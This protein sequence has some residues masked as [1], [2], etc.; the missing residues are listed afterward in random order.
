MHDKIKHL[1]DM[2]DIGKLESFSWLGSGY[3]SHAY[4]VR[5]SSGAY[6]LLEQK[7]GAG[8]SADYTYQYAVLKC[9]E[10]KKYRHAPK[11]IYLSSD[12]KTLLL[13]KVQ[14]KA[15]NKLRDVSNEDKKTIAINVADA[16]MAL[17][18]I[19]PKDVEQA[20]K[21]FGLEMPAAMNDASGWDK[22]VINTFYPYKDSAP[23][24]AQ[25][26]WI[27]KQIDGFK[28]P[29][30]IPKNLYFEHGDP[31]GENTLIGPDLSVTFID[32]EL[33]GFF[34]Y[35]EN[36]QDYELSYIM[37]D[38]PLM[39]ELRDDVLEYV[40]KKQGLELDHFK[41]IIF[42]RRNVTK[43]GDIAWAFMMYTK[44]SNGNAPD[45]PEVYKKVLDTRIKEY[46]SEFV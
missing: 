13:T 26:A 44:A 37:N 34:K 21:A 4:E 3:V 32:W 23:E 19:H 38:V 36:G 15:L 39:N 29:N 28:R 8:S 16:L 24:D 31:N 43:I 20:L 14:G 5:T 6:V 46:K 1:I 35:A 42:K 27:E 45:K 18:T 10:N 33:A 30:P 11:P 25:A 40:A 22:Y 17:Q 41:S 2:L 12:G 9:L 7:K